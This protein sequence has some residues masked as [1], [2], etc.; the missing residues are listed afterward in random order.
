MKL[1]EA[2]CWRKVCDNYMQNSAGNIPQ[3]ALSL[4]PLTRKKK[5]ELFA[6]VFDAATE[7]YVAHGT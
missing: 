7:Q 3:A 6:P 2:E 4:S 5:A 1:I